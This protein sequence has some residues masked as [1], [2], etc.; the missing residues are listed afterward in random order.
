MLHDDNEMRTQEVML[1]ALKRF[2][3]SPTPHG[4]VN[5]CLTVL[6]LASLSKEREGPVKIALLSLI[7]S[8]TGIFTVR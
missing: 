1:L 4:K 3:P 2:Y 8:F 7:P 6:Q 5:L